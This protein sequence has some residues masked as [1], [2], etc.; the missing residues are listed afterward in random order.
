MGQNE[1][2]ANLP[3]LTT[4]PLPIEPPF[5]FNGLSARVFPLRSNLDA[6]QQLVN[7]YLNIVPP[8]VGRFRVSVPY[9]YLSM[10]DYGQI[11]E[12]VLGWF[13]QV[14]VFF[15]V[16]VEWYKVVNGRWTFHDWAVITPFIYVDDDFS[17]PM[18]RLVYGFPKALARVKS[19]RNDWI[20]NVR[21]P[22]SL[23]QVETAVF[24]ELY[25]G[26]D[27]EMRVF[28]EVEQAPPMANFGLPPNT[29]SPAAPWTVASRIAEALGGA[30]RDAMWLAQAMRIFPLNPV[31]TPPFAAEMANRMGPLFDPRAPGPVLNSLNLKQFRVSN[32]PMEIAYQ[33][34]TNGPMQLMGFSEGGLLNEER[35]LLG[36]LSGGHRIKLHEF[37]TLPIVRKLGLEVARRYRGDGVDVAEL[38]P[39]MPFWMK[40]NVRYAEGMNLAWRTSDGIWRDGGGQLIESAAKQAERKA[41]PPRFNTTL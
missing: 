38:E 30:S 25:R 37:T 28:L 18:G 20:R 34:L 23:A 22:V 41:V 24:S 11:S 29:G 8:E 19:V 6:L 4:D 27:L 31:S 12:A 17:V 21:A 16:P 2:T 3:Y 13:A 7:G 14:E 39:V 1:F 9:V 32:R 15:C 10:L 26:K 35:M 33:G 5:A 36:D 40:A